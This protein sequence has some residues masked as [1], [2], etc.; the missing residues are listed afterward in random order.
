MT[1]FGQCHN[2]LNNNRQYSARF[3]GIIV[4]Y[5]HVAQICYLLTLET[6]AREYKKT[7]EILI[8]VMT[9]YS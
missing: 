7:Q 8:D 9:S 4:K 5:T 6:G 3:R 2:V 1:I